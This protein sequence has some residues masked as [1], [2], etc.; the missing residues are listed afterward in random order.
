ML[1]GT[2]DIQ[3]GATLRTSS[4][5]TSST[6]PVRMGD[7]TLLPILVVDSA[8][9]VPLIP[10]E[11]SL[12]VSSLSTNGDSFDKMQ[13]AMFILSLLHDFIWWKYGAGSIAAERLADT[14]AEFLRRR[15]SGLKEL[16]WLPVKRETVERDRH[17]L[18]IYSDFCA[19]RFGYFPLIPLK[20]T[21]F[22]SGGRHYRQVMR[23]LARKKTMLL[24]HLASTHRPDQPVA[25]AIREKTVKRRSSSRAYMNRAMIED[26]IM[27]TKSLSQRMVFTQAAF[28]GQRISE[29][30]N[31]W[32]CDVLPGRFRPVLFPDDV[33]SDV[34]L[35]VLAH[36]SQSRYVGDQR[37][38]KVDRLQF[39][40]RNYNEMVP[41]NLLEG[42]P[43]EAGWKGMLMDNEDLL[44]SQVFWADRS[45]AKVYYEM[46]QKLRDQVLPLVPQKIRNGHPYLCIN[47]ARWRDE[48]GQPMKMSN[49]LKAFERACRRIGVDPDRIPD[50]IHGLRHS[51]KALLEDLGLEPEDV[52]KSMHHVSVESQKQYAHSAAR[53][54]A[55]LNLIGDAA[56]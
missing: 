28:G 10:S 55:R 29:I 16:G 20:P 2:I 40:F 38:G 37:P 45:W 31:Q 21:P 36:P 11:A 13:G 53:L 1:S 18:C 32:R 3:E 39:L 56:R 49:I 5:R 6:F 47:D 33:A 8:D 12:F 14:I 43:M 7:G 27:A 26:L 54:N 4:S 44:I 52:R 46:F 41:R 30:L 48:F 42:F 23:Q 25:V 51:Y 34:P 50:G 24:G 19:D 35:I 15:R 9:G 17:Y 22:P